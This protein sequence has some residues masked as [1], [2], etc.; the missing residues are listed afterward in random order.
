MKTN[1][2]INLRKIARTSSIAGGILAMSF[3]TTAPSNAATTWDNSVT[4]GS[5]SDSGNWDNGVPSGA[6]GA[7]ILNTTS[8]AISITDASGTNAGINSIENSGGGSL[9]IQLGG[10]LTTTRDNSANRFS[11]TGHPLI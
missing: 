2:Y 9:S 1:T 11:N 7:Y 4:S 10:D 3:L 8:N 6:N 5:W